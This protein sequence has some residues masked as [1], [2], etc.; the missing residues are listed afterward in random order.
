MTYFKQLHPWCVVRALPS[1][2]CITVARF[3]RRED[4][5]AYLKVLQGKTNNIEF[6]VTF[7]HQ[8]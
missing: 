3:R 1:K 2:E 6:M 8:S 7:I 5:L 4:A